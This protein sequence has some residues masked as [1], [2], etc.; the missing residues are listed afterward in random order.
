MGTG[1][2]PGVKS[3]RD[4]T[5]TPHPLPVLWSWKGRATPLLLLWAVRPVQSL[6]A[7]TRVTFTFTFLYWIGR[8]IKCFP[9]G[10]SYCG[11]IILKYLY[12]TTKLSLP[13]SWKHR[14]GSR[15]IDPLILRIHRAILEV[16]HWNR[17]LGGPESQYKRFCRT[18]F[19]P[20]G[21]RTPKHPVR[22]SVLLNIAIR[23]LID[24][25]RIFWIAATVRAIYVTSV[26][27]LIQICYCPPQI[28]K[29]PLWY[30]NV[31]TYVLLTVHPCIIL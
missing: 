17:T 29:P 14:G 16:A 7:C 8:A 2:F 24:K 9:T 10:P 15:G 21:I 27:Y 3:V 4:V 26:M 5:L 20:T 31:S 19:D 13:M 22:I 1:S 12:I 30:S 25:E 18:Y 28:Y 6:S 23:F 11:K